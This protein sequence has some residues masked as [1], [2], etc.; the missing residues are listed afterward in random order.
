MA[1]E[2][3]FIGQQAAIN[4]NSRVQRNEDGLRPNM[5]KIIA[6]MI[7]VVILQGCATQLEDSQYTSLA[8]GLASTKSC[9]T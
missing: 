7:G 4:A 2:L 3:K 9:V 1:S 6:I 5:K 8:M